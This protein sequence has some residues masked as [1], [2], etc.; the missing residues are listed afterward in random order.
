MGER[1]KIIATVV[2]T[3]ASIFLFALYSFDRY[4][5][6]RA[7]RFAAALNEG[8][9]AILSLADRSSYLFETTDKYIRSLRGYYQK[10]GLS[11]LS[12][13]INASKASSF[14][15]EKGVVSINDKSG[16]VIFSTM[17][18]EGRV[19]NVSGLDHYQYFVKHPD[20][21]VYVDPTRKGLLTHMYQFRIIRPLLSDGMFDGEVLATISPVYFERY[22]EQLN[23][24]PNSSLAIL[25]LDH[26]LIA[27]YPVAPDE[28]FGKPLDHLGLW[29]EL[30]RAPAGVYRLESPI[31][32]ITRCYI[33]QTLKDYPV[34]IALGI[35]DR[36]IDDSLRTAKANAINQSIIF[37]AAAILFGLLILIIL[38]SN[39]KVLRTQAQ[40][41]ESQERLQFA[42][43]GAG[44]GVWDFD[45]V[46]HTDYW[47]EA[48]CRLYGLPKG[49]TGPG[50]DGWR[51]FLHPDDAERAHR[52]VTAALAGE[53]SFDSEFRIVLGDG[54]IRPVRSC[55]Q[56]IRDANGQ[57]SRMLGISYDLSEIKKIEAE[58]REAS[59]AAQQ[60]NRAK[61]I[62]LAN[63]SHEVRTP[64]TSVTGIVDLLRQTDLT[65]EQRGYV[66]TL[67]L[68]I[69][70]ILTIINDILDFSKIEAGRLDI[71][72]VDFNLQALIY[73]V[74]QL[75]QGAGSAKSVIVSPEG[76]DR[77]PVGAVGDPMRLRQIL[78]NLISNAIKFTERG[79]V[80]IRTAVEP[81]DGA[82]IILSV[83]IRDSGIGMSA[84][85]IDRIFDPFSQADAST[86]RKFGG[87]GL[88]LAIVKRLVDLM[89][90]TIT[91]SSTPAVGSCF[92]VRLPLEAL[93][94]N[95]QVAVR[96]NDEQ[97]PAPARLLPLRI[98]L[99][100]DNVINQRLIKAML[101]KLGHLVSV[102]AN[103]K[104]AVAAV[105]DGDYDVVL[106][107]MQMPEMDGVQATA[108][109]RS[110][111]PPQD[112]I[113]I[114]ALT[115]DVMVEHRE[116]YLKAGINDL[117]AKPIDWDVLTQS[118]AKAT[119]KAL[120]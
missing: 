35:A 17:P 86:T 60:A 96:Q 113:P 26:K 91:V 92:R 66:K 22:F 94:P 8:Q 28:L 65:D 90:G 34:V 40:L 7:E 57:A 107:D 42:T 61:S 1:A 31:D 54:T 16:V 44:I 109:I 37:A 46:T 3:V 4:N 12:D 50:Y 101:G 88:G 20:D 71:E 25:T 69:E 73:S 56:V 81:T 24:W 115:A 47:N 111:A 108:A 83:D 52:D 85:Q 104:E 103:G 93:P 2:L 75:Y 110:M 6:L 14:D 84:A 49:N 9:R 95:R 55:G 19:V 119:G 10:N 76:L 97:P 39:T 58:L 79:T 100:E 78:H 105:A 29:K 68:S 74:C 23:L 45:P 33:Y 59:E 32:G 77:L 51:S 11:G 41:I 62:F 99:A 21:V 106:M 27:R 53:K 102:A 67:A 118:L 18:L 5:G 72:T 116:R 36:D 82:R 117:V 112:R 89:G 114:I 15:R 120:T 13:L 80:T 38:R 98:L 48:M 87:T 63:M 70:S 43:E 64:I 30:D